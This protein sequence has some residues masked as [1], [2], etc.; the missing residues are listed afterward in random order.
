M[1]NSADQCR[2]SAD[3]PAVGRC[4]HRGLRAGL[5]QT[6]HLGHLY[7]KN[8]GGEVHAYLARHFGDRCFHPG[9]GG[10]YLPFRLGQYLSSLDD[11]LVETSDGPAMGDIE[12]GQSALGVT[13]LV[14][15]SHRDLLTETATCGL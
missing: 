10:S 9:S 14:S 5:D 8:S 3:R 1:G 4:L 6:A 12:C 7:A 2:C 11:H 15:D 13:H